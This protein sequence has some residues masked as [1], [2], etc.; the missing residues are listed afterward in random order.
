[1][2]YRPW[3]NHYRPHGQVPTAY[4]ALENIAFCRSFTQHLTPA[5]DAVATFPAFT[6][7][8]LIAPRV[9]F[10]RNDAD[11]PSKRLHPSL[12][13]RRTRF[14]ARRRNLPL[15]RDGRLSN[16]DLLG[17]SQLPR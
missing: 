16:D 17:G 11:A 8:L 15:R 3:S 1:M 14:R 2:V 13:R 7:V 6:Y 5:V 9:S 10:C 12:Q 4:Q